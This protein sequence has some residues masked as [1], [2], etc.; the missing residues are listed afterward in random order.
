MPTAKPLVAILMGSASDLEAVAPAFATLEQLGVPYEVR[1]ASAH[2]SPDLVARFAAR[3]AKRGIQV[4]IAAAGLAAHLPGA[5]AAQTSLPVI[6]LPLASQPLNGIDSLLS[7]VQMPPGVPV[8][9]VGINA[10]ANAALLAAQIIAL[11]DPAV[12]AELARYRASQ[13]NAVTSQNTQ[14]RKRLADTSQEG[15]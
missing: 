10:A 3:A 9:T 15:T 4:I 7:I 14:L 1:A 11:Q 6:G 2:R 13:R 8:A 5:L 12:A